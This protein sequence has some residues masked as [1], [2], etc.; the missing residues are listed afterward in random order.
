MQTFWDLF[1][2]SVILQGILTL[3]LWGT[4]IYLVIVQQPVPDLIA[5]GATSI[6]G[7]WFGTKVQAAVQA[8]TTPPSG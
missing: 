5:M 3:A 7:F 4:V 8:Q 1:K 6:L 2:Q